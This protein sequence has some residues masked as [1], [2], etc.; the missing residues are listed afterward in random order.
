MDPGTSIQGLLN[1]CPALKHLAV[2][3]S[4]CTPGPLKH[5]TIN[6]VDVFC[7][8]DGRT[9]I[10]FEWLKEGFPALQTFRTLDVTMSVLWD[11]PTS[12]FGENERR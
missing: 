8:L 3:V 12:L 9:P 2:C 6:S 7:F 10:T 1:S 4:L 11:I 5:Q